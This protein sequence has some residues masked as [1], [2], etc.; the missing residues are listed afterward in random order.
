MRV[1]VFV[2]AGYLYAEGAKAIGLSPQERY[3][4]DLDIPQAID[5]MKTLAG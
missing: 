5:K 2:D 3:M 1:A 4:L